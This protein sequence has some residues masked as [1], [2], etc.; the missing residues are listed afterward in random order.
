MNAPNP[1]DIQKS[2]DELREL[3]R[4]MSKQQN[5]TDQIKFNSNIPMTSRDVTESVKPDP[6]NDEI[7]RL[8]SDLEI[9]KS[10][11]AYLR[12]YCN[13]I[14]HELH[15]VNVA[16]WDLSGD[17]ARDGEMKLM[18]EAILAVFP[19]IKDKK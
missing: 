18:I 3:Q 11:V 17:E 1:K 13:S 14:L 4:K 2:M 16:Y 5:E 19:K 7:C 9:A 6:Q 12:D 10:E 8:R 15:K